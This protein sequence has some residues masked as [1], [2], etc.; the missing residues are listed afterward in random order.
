MC[1]FVSYKKIGMLR[2]LQFK[3]Y[4]LMIIST[5]FYGVS[6]KASIMSSR[7]RP[8]EDCP[9][10]DFCNFLFGTNNQLLL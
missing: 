2:R 5:R 4:R 8:S 7:K 9:N 3:Q 1:F 10:H 6:K